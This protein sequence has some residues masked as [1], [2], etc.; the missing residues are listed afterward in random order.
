MEASPQHFFERPIGRLSNG[1]LAVQPDSTL[2]AL[3]RR[4]SAP[5]SEALYMRYHRQIA[6]FIA[7]TLGPRRTAEDVADI[8]QEVFAAMFGALGGRDREKPFKPWLYT[9]A[10]NRAIDAIRA[11]RPATSELETETP[12]AKGEPHDALERRFDLTWVVGA[13]DALPERQREALVLREF[14]GLSYAEIAATL[15][16]TVPAVKQL[17]SR[18]RATV[19]ESASDAGVA[20]PKLA[21]AMAATAPVIISSDSWAALAARLG[22]AA[23]ASGGVAKIAAATLVVGVI[24]GA[25]VGS[26][27]LAWVSR[28]AAS[29]QHAQRADSGAPRGGPEA[30]PPTAA[31]PI[32]PDEHRGEG[33]QTRDEHRAEARRR[34]GEDRG[35]DSDRESGDGDRSGS[36][37]ESESDDGDRR[38]SDTGSREAPESSDSF[39][40]D[41]ERSG[42]GVDE[43]SDSGSDSRSDSGSGSDGESE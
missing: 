25:G 16:T 3:A 18:A 27:D 28:D 17:I 31:D 10:R 23:G 6:G 14:A 11:R 1:L 13:L 12:A 30:P 41:H 20:R 7:H 5:A 39:D 4:G 8:T 34:E 33:D 24:G 42:D 15:D 21:K 35:E 40:G 9:I 19:T 32:P 22:I 37:E 26:A 43:S 2:C 38:D 29:A 36:R